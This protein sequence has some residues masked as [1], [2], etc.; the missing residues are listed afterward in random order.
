MQVLT[1][2]ASASAVALI[3]GGSHSVA[4]QHKAA[5]APVPKPAASH[6]V[7]T[8]PKPAPDE[9][10]TV[11]S[12]DNLVTVAKANKTTWRRIYDKNTKINDPNMIYPDEKL[13]IPASDEKITDRPL[14][15][16][17]TST[18]AA[19]ASTAPAVDVSYT[20]Q[21]DP[22]P[23]PAVASGSV[24]DRIAA[25]ESGGDWAI[26]TGN[27]FYGGLQFTLGSWQAVGGS[28]LPSNASRSEQIM[29]ATMLQ[30][31]QGWGAWPVCSV[32]AGV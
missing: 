16:S 23:A 8:P 5:A 29:R 18:A 2:L 14:P 31:R 10:V 22:T 9:T 20:A 24:W 32:K 7:A 13:V 6:A 27:G 19:P 26:N 12:G 21:P 30:A 28:G 4:Q 17:K 1:T 11:N 15:A 25:C 3:V